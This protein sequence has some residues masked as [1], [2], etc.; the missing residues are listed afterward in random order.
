MK[1]YF[2]VTDVHGHFTHMMESLKKDGFDENNP[3]HIFVSLGDLLDRGRENLKC[4]R[5][6]N[7]LKKENKILI[8]GNHEDL[9]DACLKRG[10]FRSH[11]YPNGTA[12]TVMDL[13]SGNCKTARE[14][15]ITAAKNEELLKYEE[16]LVNFYEDDHFVFVHGW[17]PCEDDGKK[18]GNMQNWRE[19]SWIEARWIAGWRAWLDCVMEPSKTI[20][21]GHWH[22]SEP[23]YL[24]HGKEK[25]DFS[26]F[27]DE[28]IVSMDSCVAYSKHVNC[29]VANELG[30]I[31]WIL[32]YET[33]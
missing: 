28:G 4:L 20:F 1:K 17:I 23:N 21:C 26:P 32:P 27:I 31:E 3:G 10:E 13:C 7:S 25:E 30:E 18:Y 2:I 19:G 33:D 12:E 6:V 9:L 11:D 29:I 15:F 5:F 22:C 16:D 24:I 14:V 8:R